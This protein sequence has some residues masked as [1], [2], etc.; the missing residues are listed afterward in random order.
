MLNT[1]VAPSDASLRERFGR[2][3]RYGPRLL[4]GLTLVFLGGV[5]AGPLSD[6]DGWWHFRTGELILDRGGI[7]RR[8]PFTWTA[9]GDRWR[10]NSWAS[11]VIFEL[12]RQAGGLVGV[13]LL[14]SA[15]FLAVLAAVHALARRAGAR[16][17]PAAAAVLAVGIAFVPFVNERPQMFSYL[18][19]AVVALLAPPALAGS[20]AAVAGLAV[21]GAAWANLHGVVVLGLAAVAAIA[22]GDAVQNRRLL[23]PAV[24]ALVGPIASLA[25]P[26]G[27]EIYREAGAIRALGRELGIAEYRRPD[28]TNSLDIMVLAL[29]IVAVVGL[30]RSGRGRSPTIVL[31][32]VLLAANAV[33][34]IR[35]VP[36]FLVLAAPEI[37][38][39][40]GTLVSPAWRDRL[41]RHHLGPLALGAALL[42]GAAA[43]LGAINIT[44]AGEVDRSGFPVAATGAIPAGCR[45]LN[46]YN[47]GGY[48]IFRRWP[49]VAVSQDS[50]ADIFGRDL[51]VE[52][53]EILADD[54]GADAEAWLR[55]NR[56]DCV[57][58]R[59][60]RALVQ[61]L[62]TSPEWREVEAEKAGVLLVRRPT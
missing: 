55:R 21:T 46:E 19:L 37:A 38:L 47:Q 7:P 9:L 17:W 13:A 32:L 23:L 42:V 4:L 59:P 31:P 25:N 52:Q 27:I 35:S 61:R 40:F 50:R 41:R 29:A 54:A 15:L 2:V 60:E 20:N 11:D 48:I 36:M 56:V 8:D 49:E 26:Y 6:N 57:L 14:R 30:V 51:L 1:M 39:A 24:V 58:A 18:L 16:P 28:V 22:A 43:V 53:Q 33:D 44:R 3:D 45:V 5:G 10:P 34:G 62:R 12:V